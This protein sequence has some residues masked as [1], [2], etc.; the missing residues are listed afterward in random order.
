MAE[1]W[2]ID[3]S[4]SHVTFKVRHLIISSTKGRFRKF[5]GHVVLD[6]GDLSRSELHADV[7]VAS[8]DT[9]MRER[10]EAIRGKDF[11]DAARFPTMSFRST[12]VTVRGRNKL[13]V[14]GE[15]SLKSV[16]RP[17]ALE[18]DLSSARADGRRRAKASTHLSRKDFNL[19]WSAAVETGG[20]AVG[21][22]VDIELDVELVRAV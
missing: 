9:D 19:V 15:L 2:D 12:F 17:V 7:D 13:L 6:E 20:I 3:A 14:Q 1:R 18:V 10:D 16:R 22:R 8:V 5:H 4:G 21:D 11:F